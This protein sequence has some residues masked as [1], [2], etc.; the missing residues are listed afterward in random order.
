MNAHS[1]RERKHNSMHN[2]LCNCAFTGDKSY[3]VWSNPNVWPEEFLTMKETQRVKGKSQKG[4]IHEGR[5]T[6][7]I[8]WVSLW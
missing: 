5:L 3:H 2:A 1:R 8:V 4:S 7:R 6:L